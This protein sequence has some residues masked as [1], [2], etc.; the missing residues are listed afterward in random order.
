MSAAVEVRG[1]VKRYGSLAAVDGIDLTVEA[2]EIFSILGPNGAGKSTTV[3]ILEGYRNRDAGEVMVLGI[4]PAQNPA[5]WRSNR[6]GV[7]GVKDAR[8]THGARM[9]APVRGLLWQLP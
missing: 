1:L 7:A 4:D 5:S 3:E 2:G 9:C 8:R 6:C